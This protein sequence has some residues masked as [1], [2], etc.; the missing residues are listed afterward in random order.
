MACNALDVTPDCDEGFD[1]ETDVVGS[2][3]PIHVIRVL[4]Y[5][6]KITYFPSRSGCRW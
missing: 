2:M 5:E 3:G 6:G 1:I 4:G